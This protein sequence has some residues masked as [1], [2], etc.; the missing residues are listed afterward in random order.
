MP[1]FRARRGSL[2]ALAVS[3]RDVTQGQMGLP[4]SRVSEFS[5]HAQVLR[6]RSV[7][8]PLPK[9]CSWCCLPDAYDTVGAWENLISGAQLA[10]LRFPL[11]G[12]SQ[13]D[14]VTFFVAP[15]PDL[16]EWLD[17]PLREFH[18]RFRTGFIPA[19]HGSSVQ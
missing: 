5:T 16:Q 19:S 18:S 9:R 3:H 11:H 12:R 6:L 13:H 1:E 7:R 17:L 10:G 2:V 14:V 8:L 4:G 15:P